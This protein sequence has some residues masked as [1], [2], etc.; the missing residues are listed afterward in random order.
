MIL[1]ALYPLVSLHGNYEN[2]ANDEITVNEEGREAFLFEEVLT[3]F[4][5]RPVVRGLQRDDPD[6]NFGPPGT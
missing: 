1:T 3:S 4:R 6:G 2:I 5:Y